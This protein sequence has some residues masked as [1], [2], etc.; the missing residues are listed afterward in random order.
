MFLIGLCGAAGAGK[1]TVAARLRERWGFVELSFA[2]P[3]YRM[4]AEM[5]GL[6]TSA[7]QDR[8]LKERQIDWLGK[9][10]R[11]LLQMLGTEFG[12]G[13]ISEDIWVLRA[14]SEFDSIASG[15]RFPGCV[16]TDVRFDNEAKAIV[17]RGGQVWR[18]VR[19]EGDCV[20]G[21]AMRHRSEAGVS[22]ELVS[23]VIDNDGTIASLHAS[24]DAAWLR[25]RHRIGYALVQ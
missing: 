5:T 21:S 18:V 16:I 14:M 23:A 1:N 17:A 25:S 10:P 19:P 3:L 9:S 2:A 8:A 6:P 11:E 12:R 22:G 13:M 4:V 15:G 7:L 24:I 20:S